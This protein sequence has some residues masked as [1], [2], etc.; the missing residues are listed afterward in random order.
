VRRRI[1]I[2]MGTTLTV[3]VVLYFGALALIYIFSP[4]PT[5]LG[6]VEGRLRPCPNKPNCVCT[7]ATDERHK[8]DAIAFTGTP[9]EAIERLKSVV[10][11]MPRMKIVT[12]EGHYMHVECR[13]LIMRF[14]DDVEF[15]VDGENKTIHFR[16]ASRLGY[17]DWG[18]NRRRMEAIRAAF[19]KG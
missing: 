14:V 3:L 6:L 18:V 5:D 10:K 19:T 7:Q 8:I 17:G 9:E 13:T 4:R 1:L 11:S 12:A 15:A 16:S 2:G